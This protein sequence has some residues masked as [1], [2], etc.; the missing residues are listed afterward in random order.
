[1][2]KLFIIS[3]VLL[4]SFFALALFLSPTLAKNDKDSENE[5]QIIPEQ[6]GTYDVP[7]H[8]EMK[9]RVFVHKAR[10]EPAPLPLLTCGLSDPESNAVVDPLAYHLP[11]DKAWTYQLNPSSDPSSVRSNLSIFAADAFS[12]WTSASGN[13]VSFIKGSDTLTSRKA[14]DGKNIIAWGRISG[15]A[16]GITY[17]WYYP[18]TGLMAETD[19]IMNT[20]FVW[21]WTPYNKNNLCAVANTYDAQDILT[22]ELGHW[23]GLNDEYATD[24][25]DNTMFGYGSKSEVKK[26]T[27]TDGDI[28]GINKIY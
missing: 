17:M 28:S 22:H 6:D 3:L 12:R 1:M 13:K 18:S 9:V 19:T 10:P 5:E 25:A 15:S 11:T 26:D 4:F 7:G 14:L 27:L 16:L 20:K 23:M 2:R 24:Y 8:P 21:S